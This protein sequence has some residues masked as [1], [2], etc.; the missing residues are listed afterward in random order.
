MPSLAILRP[1]CFVGMS[2]AK[3]CFTDT[4]L[5]TIA[6]TYD[7]A[8]YQAPLVLGHPADDASSPA[9]GWVRS[10]AI[11]DD[12]ALLADLENITPEMQALVKAGRYRQLSAS[13]W[14][15]RHP[16]NP[17][18]GGFSLRHLGALGASGPAI[19]GLSKLAFA[20]PMAFACCHPTLSFAAVYQ[21]RSNSTL[22][23]LSPRIALNSRTIYANRRPQE[24]TA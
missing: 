21:R 12:G 22:L 15:P 10:L 20:E 23:N 2:G 8:R 6:A 14:P 3:S 4:D 5:K 16:G 1:G 11:G 24:H 19:S 13:L 9:H 17:S 18:P 7:P